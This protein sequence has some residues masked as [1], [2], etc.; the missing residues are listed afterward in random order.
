MKF[1]APMLR[2]IERSKSAKLD[3]GDNKPPT[4]RAALGARRQA[5]TFALL[6]FPLSIAQDATAT[7]A[8]R[9][10]AASEVAEYFLPKKT[11]G[12]KSPHKKFPPDE[13][14]FVVDPDLAR[15]LRD[16]KWRLASLPLAQNITPYAVAQTASKLQM[17]IRAIQQT[18]QCPCPSKY[19]LEE[20]ERDRQRLNSFGLRRKSRDILT[21]KEDKEE[22][23]RIA[24][25]DSFWEGPEI[26]ARQRLADLREKKRGADK[27]YMRPL[28]RAEE[29]TYRYL[30]L[31]YPPPKS[32]GPDEGTL[33]E[34]PFHNLPI[35]EDNPSPPTS[36][37][38]QA[39]ATLGPD[40][41]TRAEH[42]FHDLPIS[43]GNPSPPTSEGKQAGATLSGLPNLSTL[44]PN[45][46]EIEIFVK[47]KGMTEAE[48]KA[49][50]AGHVGYLCETKGGNLFA[51]KVLVPEAF[52]RLRV[53]IYARRLQNRLPET[54]V[55]AERRE[56]E[57]W[58]VTDQAEINCILK[59]YRDF[60][61]LC[62]RKEAETGEPCLIIASYY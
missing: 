46:M 55:V 54:L 49:Q 19:G 32:A 14:G 28:T 16:N 2:S 59:S 5:R 20:I 50:V 29:T 61:A 12:T 11:G 18:L 42:P 60:V 1:V 57:D 58:G 17:R 53:P 21:F 44:I 38:T 6:D 37:G 10:K 4:N 22:A 51:T 3:R 27:G 7:P 9:R 34:H 43:E 62:A 26:A 40:E 15:E 41:R 35:A 47:W 8:E 39:G 23:H 30:A 36:E 56:R 33:A 24:R 13:Y 52:E 31:L 45:R 48:E 25:Y